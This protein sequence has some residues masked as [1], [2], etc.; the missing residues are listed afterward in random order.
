VT[1]PVDVELTVHPGASFRR[2]FRWLPDGDDAQDLTG[3]TATL[4]IGPARGRA[5]YTLTSAPGGGISLGADGL[6]SVVL[7]AEETADMTGG[8]WRYVIDLRAPDGTVTR[9]LR[10]RL[11]V[12]NDVG[13]AA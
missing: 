13:A 5:A 12:V 6:I 10:G 8:A 7:H 9:L 4:L 11:I 3:Y 2:E 1:A